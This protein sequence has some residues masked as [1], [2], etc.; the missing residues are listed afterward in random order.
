MMSFAWWLSLAVGFLSLSQEILWVRLVSFAFQGIPHVFSFV[1][2]NFLIGIALGA[3]VGK[4]FCGRN[5]DLY[6]VG[7]AALMVA[8]VTDL[9]MPLIAAPFL[10]RG[11]MSLPWLPLAI[12]GTAAIKSV[13]FPI[14]HHLGSN[15]SGP[16]VGSSVSKIYFGNII[17][18]TLGPIVTGFFL[19]DR[20]TVEQCFVV[21]GSACLVLSA[22][23]A[24]HSAHRA[25]RMVVV[26]L[27]ALVALPAATSGP[28][29]TVSRIAIRAPA[30]NAPIT[31]IIQNKHGILHTVRDEKLGDIVFGGNVYDGRINV[32]T[33]VNS[34]GLERAYVLA[35]LHPRAKR[36]LVVGMSTGAWTRVLSGFPD[37]QH[38]DVVEINSGYL[39][40][41]KAYPEVAPLLNDPRIHIHIDD[42]RRWLKRH[43]DAMYD[44]IVQNT[45]FYWRS[46][47]TNLLSIEYFREVGRHM[48]PGA[49]I[50]TNTTYSLDVYRTAQE[51][52]PFAFKYR[53]CV[54][55]GDSD[56]R[57]AT[58][59]ALGRLRLCR[60]GDRPAF[61]PN[62]FEPGGLAYEIANENVVP[63]AEILAQ[64]HSVPVD[65]ITDQNLLVE[66]R[67]GYVITFAP[68]R[69]LLPANP[70]AVNN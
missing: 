44:L 31:H 24:L 57:M 54:Y 25:V 7:A 64:Q 29:D 36:I 70:H 41:V 48:L 10:G 9:L 35:A 16:K 17:G 2:A 6:A 40:L 45:T 8:A 60:I 68:L 15:Q 23:T 61:R 19:L 28:I 26:T 52:F 47:S 63:V 49:I 46:N 3:L 38:I 22:V 11:Q 1:L 21:V 55:A 32:D 14:A 65:V 50:M 37:V 66:Y 67:H 12:I 62:Q 20:L 51:A 53:N 30:S 69:W 33:S 34:N 58:E 43:P 13:L 18:S 4:W 39:E 5:K 27:C 59:T 56:F 42:G